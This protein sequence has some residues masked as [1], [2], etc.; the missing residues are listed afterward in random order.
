MRD[1]LVLLVIIHLDRRVRSLYSSVVQYFQYFNRRLVLASPE[2]ILDAIFNS[3][4]ANESLFSLLNHIIK[5]LLKADQWRLLIHFIECFVN[6][7]LNSGK[8]R[9]VQLHFDLWIHEL[10]FEI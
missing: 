4:V 1:L 5:A 8:H 3:I 6:W 7:L 2:H 10:I 9:F